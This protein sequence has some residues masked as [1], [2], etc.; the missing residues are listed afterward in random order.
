MTDSAHAD[1]AA[2]ERS[3]RRALL[4]AGAIGA[5]LALAGS[6]PAAASTELSDD[7]LSITE[8]AIALEL[9]AR[10]LY[11]VAIAAGASDDVW[12]VMREQHEAYA[13]RLAG[14]TGISANQRDDATFDAFESAFDASDPSAPALELENIAAATHTELLGQVADIGVSA[15][16]A[17]FAAME[18]RHATVLAAL[19]GQGDDLDALFS[20]SATALSPEA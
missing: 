16:M 3:S 5:V 7:D 1:H 17:S 19:S 8:F 18:S 20:N 2:P 11:D 9:T 14:I 15:A 4:G 6:R 12:H 13:V 10:D